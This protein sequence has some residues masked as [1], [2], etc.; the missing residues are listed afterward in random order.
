MTAFF[1]FQAEDGIRDLY[2]T[3]VQTCALPI[4]A[5]RD[6]EVGAVGAHREIC[7]ASLVFVRDPVWE[8]PRCTGRTAHEQCLVAR[9]GTARDDPGH[10]G[11]KAASDRQSSGK[12]GLLP[13]DTAYRDPQYGHGTGP[14]SQSQED[15]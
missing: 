6:G 1:F 3:G 7:A 11:S 4:Y 5:G 9:P 8:N 10:T 13:N 14:R 15:S 2:V 12:S